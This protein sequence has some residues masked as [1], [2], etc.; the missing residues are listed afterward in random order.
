MLRDAGCDVTHCLAIF[1]Y[2]L[3][4]AQQ[5]FEH[6]KISRLFLCSIQDL[7][8]IAETSGRLLAGERKTVEQWL[9]DYEERSKRS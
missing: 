5:A 8:V 1:D 7:L 6:A 2:G 3:S 4:C 9:L